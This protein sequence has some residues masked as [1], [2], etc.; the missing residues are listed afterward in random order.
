MGPPLP[1]NPWVWG[2]RSTTVPPP[3]QKPLNGLCGSH[4]GC[5]RSGKQARMRHPQ[6]RRLSSPEILARTLFTRRK[7]CSALS[8]LTALQGAAANS[9]TLASVSKRS[10]SGGGVQMAWEPPG[11]EVAPDQTFS[12]HPSSAADL[13]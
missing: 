3:L 11:W 8:K 10:R 6:V 13:L 2:L 5:V 7:K 1:S 4:W 12:L 9:E